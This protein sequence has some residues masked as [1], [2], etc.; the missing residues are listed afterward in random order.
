MRLLFR[1]H[2]YFSWEQARYLVKSGELAML[3]VCYKD[4]VLHKSGRLWPSEVRSGAAPPRHCGPKWR[5]ISLLG[6]G[7][8]RL[9][10]VSIL[11]LLVIFA[12]LLKWVGSR[13]VNRQIYLSTSFVNKFKLILFSCINKLRQVKF[14]EKYV[15]SNW[16][17]KFLNIPEITCFRIS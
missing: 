7:F 8:C 14:I 15:R 6:I 11:F 13:H 9:F 17:K 5:S 1:V 3:A 2:S 12:P 10:T 16:I 4:F